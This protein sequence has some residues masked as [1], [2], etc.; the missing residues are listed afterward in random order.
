MVESGDSGIWRS[1]ADG[2][3]SGQG[4]KEYPASA[5]SINDWGKHNHQIFGGFNAI[6]RVGGGA[7]NY[8]Q[9]FLEC[10]LGEGD[11]YDPIFS[12]LRNQYVLAA[13]FGMMQVGMITYNQETSPGMLLTS[14][15]NLMG[16]D[17]HMLYLAKY[18]RVAI[19]VG[20]AYDK[21]MLMTPWNRPTNPFMGFN[22]EC[23]ETCTVSKLRF[24]V[25]TMLERY[26]GSGAYPTAVIDLSD[27]A[28]GPARIEYFSTHPEIWRKP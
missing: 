24:S 15:Y 27:V 14:E 3:P 7:H 4:R 9:N 6:L 2:D 18:P 23:P 26:N 19:R 17:R 12:Y 5:L 8:S 16:P 11:L 20:S 1:D 25:R 28:G 21:T 10:D 13:S 22:A